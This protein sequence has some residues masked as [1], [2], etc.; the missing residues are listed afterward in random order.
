MPE[1][2]AA[3]PHRF[4]F[5]QLPREVR[6]R[7]REGQPAVTT[8]PGIMQMFAASTLV[9]KGETCLR[10]RQIGHSQGRP[11]ERQRPHAERTQNLDRS[12]APQ[13]ELPKTL[14]IKIRQRELCGRVRVAP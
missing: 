9:A 7:G 11:A 4:M 1:T 8:F 10:Q 2:P 13:N 3:P 6:T 12:P 5:E 14:G